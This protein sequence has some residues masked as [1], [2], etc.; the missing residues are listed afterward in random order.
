M[1]TGQVSDSGNQYCERLGL[2]LP[3][4]DAA[5][6]K[7]DLK[8]THLM[9]LTLLEAGGPLSLEAV[10]ERLARLALPPRLAAAGLPASLRKA[11]HGQPPVV[12]DPVDGRFYLDL[13]CH[14]DL[15]YLAYLATPIS[16]VTRLGPDDFRQP[17]DTVPLSEDEVDA[18]FRDRT[19]YGYS[20]IRRAAAILE[21]SGGEPLVAR[22]AATDSAHLPARGPRIRCRQPAGGRP[23]HD[24]QAQRAC[25]ARSVAVPPWRTL[26][27]P[28]RGQARRGGAG[29]VRALRVRRAPRRRARSQAPG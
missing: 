5:L 3:D 18:A 2:S 19:L 29:V 14:H 12:R 8:L 7:P 15:R 11:W 10:A 20:S 23:G 17:P 26:D 1:T 25:G 28:S 16:A 9:A 27:H 24:G 6:T 4:L 13:L 22:G 21:A